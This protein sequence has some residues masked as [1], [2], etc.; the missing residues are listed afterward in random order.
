VSDAA[1]VALDPV[2]PSHQGAAE[3]LSAGSPLRALRRLDSMLAAALEA[4]RARYGDD[5]ESDAFRGLYVTVD[6]ASGPLHGAVGVPLLA[7][8]SP[9]EDLRGSV[10][11]WAEI[12][13]THGGWKW[14]RSRYGLSDRDMDV[15]LVAL[16][17]EVDLRFERL[18]GYLQDDVSR[19]RPTVD[20][21]LDL[22][23]CSAADKLAARES[24]AADAP[25]VAQR[26]LRLVPEQRSV[27]PPLLANTLKLDDQIVD[28]L[29]GQGGLDRRLAG[30]CT[31]VDP[32]DG[33]Q[34]SSPL[35]EDEHVGLVAAVRSAWQQRPLRIVF[36]GPTGSGRLRA[37]KAIAG[38]VGI[39]LLVVDVAQIPAADDED[40]VALAVR[41]AELQGALLYL[42]D[43]DVAD[44]GLRAP[45]LRGLRHLAQSPGAMILAGDQVWFPP[46]APALGELRVSFAGQGYRLRRDAW[47]RGLSSVS[48]R[49]EDLD[50]L[51]TRYRLR[52][53]QIA[54]AA[55]VALE[56]GRARAAAEGR[57]SR[58]PTTSELVEAARGQGGQDLTRQARRIVPLHGW[59]DLVLP[60]DSLEQ[61][62]EMCQ[63]VALR[64]Q[65]LTDW[66]FAGQLSQ[67][68]GCAALFSG[69]SG[70]GK[71]MA[72]E[73]VAGELGLD[74]YKIDL[75][76]VVSKY[77][78]ETE[79]NLER[80]F[81]AA[82]HA[83]AILFF[84]E[85]DALFGKRSEVRDAHDKYANIETA[86]LLQRMEQYDGVAIL[87]TNLRQNL[88]DAFTRR[89]QF[90]IEFPFPDEDQRRR[91]WTVCLPADAP[92]APG[93]DLAR[94]GR[95]YRLAGGNIRNAVLH[96]AYRAAARASPITMA[97][98]LYAVRRE[99]QKMGKVLGES[100][101]FPTPEQSGA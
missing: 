44:Q 98:L 89:L 52:P 91:I 59:D 15:V 3:V 4:A 58:A 99:H 79:R 77:I 7:A 47:A 39:P 87:A 35:P 78:G 23:S 49:D 75:S 38:E 45:V 50:L 33:A 21:A 41:E 54:A 63:Q 60:D 28:L 1:V 83:D 6:Q 85:A 27:P 9:A 8:R 17:P 93:L 81:A 68:R 67:G 65:V 48:V 11:A 82:D 12:C 19:R 32:H 86:Y 56:M 2:S 80:I 26:I 53:G 90:L 64:E 37:A 10:P 101:S 92:L 94:L 34:V 29:L 13:S 22:L 66:G 31:L 97:D 88:D 100:D 16:A 5:A 70:T 69:P 73:V 71:T 74:L 84:D 46:G 62:R 43:V 36:Q 51:A 18:Y 25:L 14:L 20:L 24:F 57:V 76:R 30:W 55:A 42:H 61:L 96:A 40:V 72:A 95:D